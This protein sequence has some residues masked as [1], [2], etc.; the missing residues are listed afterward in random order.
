MFNEFNL[1]YF[2]ADK[3]KACEQRAAKAR[4]LKGVR[5]GKPSLQCLI[6]EKLAGFLV[7]IGE[8]LKALV[9]NKPQPDELPVVNFKQLQH[10]FEDPAPDGL[11][12]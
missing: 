9:Q 3:Q 11:F 6:C 12:I 7:L 4:L 5:A 8:D 10:M 2:A 1:S